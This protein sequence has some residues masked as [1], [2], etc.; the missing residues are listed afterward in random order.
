VK[1]KTVIRKKSE[2]IQNG[3]PA[4]GVAIGGVA[5]GYPGRF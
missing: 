5:F 4:E 1:S 2:S 3:M